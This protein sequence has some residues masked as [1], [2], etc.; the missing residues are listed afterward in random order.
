MKC[1]VGVVLSVR[2]ILDGAE[3][4]EA[5][6]TSLARDERGAEATCMAPRVAMARAGGGA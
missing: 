6:P 2:G 4:P 3:I 5:M 1:K